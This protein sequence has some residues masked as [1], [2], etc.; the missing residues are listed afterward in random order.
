MPAHPEVAEAR[1]RAMRSD[2]INGILDA[3]DPRGFW[4]K[5]GPGYAPK[6]SGTVWNL[7]FLEQ[8][9]AAAKELNVSK[10]GKK[11]VE[12]SGA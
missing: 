11:V 6:Y 8:M 1:A 9:G 2:P 5:P 4:V 7:M 10:L 12:A 3:M